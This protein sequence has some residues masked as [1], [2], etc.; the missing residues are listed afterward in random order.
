MK[1]RA[2]NYLRF[3]KFIL[4]FCSLFYFQNL[5]TA[6][7]LTWDGGGDGTSFG[8][9]MNWDLDM[10]PT[11]NDVTIITSATV[12][13]TNSISVAAIH[14]L[15]SSEL[16]IDAGV[17]VNF[18][19]TTGGGVSDILELDDDAIAINR[20][21]LLFD[22][23]DMSI[24]INLEDN[25]EFQ[26]YGRIIINGRGELFIGI[27]MD[28][29]NV[30]LTNEMG[31]YIEI[32]ETDF[33][34]IQNDGPITNH[35]EIIIDQF[36]FI[37]IQLDAFNPSSTIVFENS[38]TLTLRTDSINANEFIDIRNNN[39]LRNSGVI[40]LQGPVSINAF[41]FS[42]SDVSNLTNERCGIINIESQSNLILNSA[43]D[44]FIN[45]GIYATAY[46]G[47]NTNEGTIT[48]NGRIQT[49]DGMF[50]LVGGGT[51]NGTGTIEMGI[52]PENVPLYPD[53]ITV[54]PTLS[55]W[56]CA[57]LALFMLILAITIIKQR[58]LKKALL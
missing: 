53:C 16:M 42:G 24:C 33:I 31:A 32:N 43:N 37:G 25:S 11:S 40:N 30:S 34:P 18:L 17:T 3:K 26:N 1:F 28:G 54:V 2:Q 49:A 14:L 52:V 58:S 46:T 10:V 44:L 12:S 35:G 23:D 38:G 55:Q 19:N 4:L 27:Q 56:A 39:A 15:G 50:N 29:E 48:N 36:G 5:S 41:D 21:F 8:D 22:N 57:I 20:G 6:A 51:L 45:D 7:T 9:A 47:S 13:I